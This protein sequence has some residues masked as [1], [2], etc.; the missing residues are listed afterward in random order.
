MTQVIEGD[1]GRVLEWKDAASMSSKDMVLIM[2]A[3][4]QEHQVRIIDH[5]SALALVDLREDDGGTMPVIYQ[6]AYSTLGLICAI[7]GAIVAFA[8]LD[9]S[10]PNPRPSRANPPDDT[11]TSWIGRIL[12]RTGGRKRR[13]RTRENG[14]ERTASPEKREKSPTPEVEKDPQELFAAFDL[15][16]RRSKDGAGKDRSMTAALSSA[17]P[18]FFQP[19]RTTLGYFDVAYSVTGT[20]KLNPQ[21]RLAPSDR[22]N[23]SPLESLGRSQSRRLGQSSSTLVPSTPSSPTEIAPQ[24]EDQ[25]SIRDDLLKTAEYE[26][27]RRGSETTQVSAFEKEDKGMVKEAADSLYLVNSLSRGLVSDEA[28]IYNTRFAGSRNQL[29]TSPG[30]IEMAV[31]GMHAN[32]FAPPSRQRSFANSSFRDPTY[33]EFVSRAAS[34]SSFASAGTTQAGLKR[35]SLRLAV[36]DDALDAQSPISPPS[37]TCPEDERRLSDEITLSETDY[38]SVESIEDRD[39]TSRRRRLARQALSAAIAGGGISAMREL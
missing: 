16:K 35:S 9:F 6:G 26:R 23:L 37:I 4:L 7:V 1:G 5:P 8:L 31:G 15:S 30:A 34:T 21:D 25:S 39:R 22:G 13:K 2:A 17:P 12:R 14:R 28:S 29:V 18:T 11:G 38:D 24:K 20:T 27:Y 19:P 10:H 32:L 3:T 36:D 33:Q